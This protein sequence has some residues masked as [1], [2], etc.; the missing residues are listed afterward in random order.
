[1]K[2]RSHGGTEPVDC[3]LDSESGTARAVAVLV[4]QNAGRDR[5]FSR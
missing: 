3:I 4:Y 5:F 1:M 2:V